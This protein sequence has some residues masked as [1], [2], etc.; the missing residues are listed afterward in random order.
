MTKEGFG[1]GAPLVPPV[2][3]DTGTGMM[4]VGFAGQQE[5]QMMFPTLVGR[6]MLRYDQK[7]SSGRK[8]GDLMIGDD[9]NEIRGNAKLARPIRNG[10]VNDWQ[11]MEA[12]WEHTFKSLGVDPSQHKIVQTEAALNPPK[13]RE[14]IVE[15][16][17][18]K[19]GFA[20]VNLSVQ[21]ILA[22]ASQGLDTGFVVDSGDGVTHLVPVHS[23]YLEPSM[24]KRVNLAGRHITEHMMKLLVGQGHALNDTADMETV[25]EMKQKLCYVA[26]DVKKEMKLATDTTLVERKYTLP[27]SREIRI[28][29][30][31]FLG[32]ELIFD[33]QRFGQEGERG[34]LVEH[35]FNCIRSAPMDH[36][37]DFFNHIVLS[38]G[39]T[40]FPGL[41]SRLEKDLRWM[42]F[43]KVLQRDTTR[44]FKFKCRVEDHPRRQH[45]VFLGASI[46]ANAYSEGSEW[47]ITPKEYKEQGARV[48]QRLMAST[49]LR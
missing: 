15:I 35:V 4:K 27:D 10:I 47:W 17:F 25:R 30:E 33:P 14:K 32:P 3:C 45:M 40:M 11:D 44:N 38:G 22:L 28:G 41:S 42:Y 6:P 43:D 7:L 13:N 8:V 24:V 48:V 29:A 46:L 16:M 37:K 9:A 19:F 39:T 36:Q 34:G 20:G 26:L 2:I 49:Q 1:L 31:R 21:A 23:G 5:P 12:V 18:E